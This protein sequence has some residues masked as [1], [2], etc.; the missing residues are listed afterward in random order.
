VLLERRGRKW[1][2]R[3]NVRKEVSLFEERA[4]GAQG[5]QRGGAAEE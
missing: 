4:K 1:G 5:G 2:V 3:G